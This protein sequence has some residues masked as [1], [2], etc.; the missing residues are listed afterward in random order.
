MK[1]GRL[2][3]CLG[4]FSLFLTGCELPEFLNNDFFSFLKKDEKKNEEKPDTENKENNEENNENNGNKENTNNNENSIPT[5]T[6][7]TL[8]QLLEAFKARPESY[9]TDVEA[10]VTLPNQAPQ[11]IND[12]KEN[13][14]AIA[15]DY[16]LVPS[17]EE[18][19]SIDSE[20]VTN[21]SIVKTY[22][23]YQIDLIFANGGTSSSK[24]DEAFYVLETTQYQD[25]E[26]FVHIEANFWYDISDKSFTFKEYKD[27][28]YTE[29]IIEIL[30]ESYLSS[31]VT[32]DGNSI[33]LR[34]ESM[35]ATIK[36]DYTQD[37]NKISYT[38]KQLLNDGE[39]PRDITE[40]SFEAHL[41][42]HTIDIAVEGYQG[43]SYVIY[44]LNN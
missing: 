5:G 2:F 4:I 37:K 18:V 42:G 26:L 20:Y 9:Y 3:C 13:N 16:G 29:D 33:Y 28:T 31:F 30:N 25:G 44:R 32:F 40:M 17:D 11:I 12:S 6:E 14:W 36:G 8:E 39:A 38:Y 35:K 10:I 19:E 41:L 7:V 15:D 43:A 21:V 1:K 23:G 24:M 27:K 22:F 34:S